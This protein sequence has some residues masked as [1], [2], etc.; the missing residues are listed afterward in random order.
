MAY[1]AIDDPEAYF[2]AQ[3]YSGNGTAIGSGGLSVTL[4]G[5]T[6]M[7]PDAVYI[8]RRDDSGAGN[9]SDAVRGVPRFLPLDGSTDGEETPAEGLTAF[10]SDGFTCGN[11]N[12]VNN[13]S[14]TYVAWCWKESATAG[15]DLV[16]YTGSG[17]ARTISHSLSAVP[18]FIFLKN[19]G[20]ADEWRV[21]HAGNTSAPE[22]DYLTFSTTAATAD[23]AD[24][25]NDTAP[26]SSVFSLG[27]G[28]EVNTNTE[29]YI[30]YL[31][32]EKQGFSKFGGYTGN[33]DADG[34]FVYT[35]F[36]PAFVMC[37]STASTSDWHI[38]DDQREGYNVDND[39][40]LVNSAAAEATTDMIDIL[41]N[42]FKLRIAT[43]PNVNE[44]YIY[45]AFAKAPL[46]NSEGV[47]CN[48]R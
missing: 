24:V 38:F 26:T 3:A 6:A 22:T 2:Q 16:G 42:G 4:D 48:A 44:T 29:N 12:G 21:Y 10:N 33:G 27:D 5:D 45:M 32:S 39:P 25:W 28:D 34:T 11:Y 9:L 23:A 18:K 8:K 31:W 7:Q 30:A 47:P 41:S 14:G 1:T 37:K 35:G 15:F 40:L 17:S 20:A 36:R 13:G 43:D 46:V 19:R